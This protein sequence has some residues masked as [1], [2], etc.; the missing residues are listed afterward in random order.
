MD[1]LLREI[2]ALGFRR[3]PERVSTAAAE[4]TAFPSENIDAHEELVLSRED[5]SGTYKTVCHL[6]HK[7]KNVIV[8]LTFPY[9]KLFLITVLPASMAQVNE[10]LCVPT[11][12]V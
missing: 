9:W 12:T 5:A 4:N 10:T 2:D 7:T 1:Q 8:N 11:G 3:E 6:E